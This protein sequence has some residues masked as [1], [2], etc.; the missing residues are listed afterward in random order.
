MEKQEHPSKL[1]FSPNTWWKDNNN[2]YWLM[3]GFYYRGGNI[4]TVE[5]QEVFTDYRVWVP[6]AVVQNKYE[7]QELI[8]I[9]KTTIT[10]GTDVPNK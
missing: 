2:R 7:K 1:P 3:L 9:T 4:H 5:M 8:N 6:I 10:G